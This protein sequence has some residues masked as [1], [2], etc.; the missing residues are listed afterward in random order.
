MKHPLHS[1]CPYFAMFPGDFAET[2][3]LSYTRMGDTVLDPFSGRGTTI[4]E[5]LLHGRTAIG[6]DINPVA[7]CIAGAKAD[8]PNLAEV[9]QRIEALEAGANV[10]TVGAHPNDFFR[11]CFHTTTFS[12]VSYLREALDWTGCRIDRFIAAMTLGALHGESHRSEMYLSNR[13]PRT[14]STK[15]DYSIRWWEKNGYIAPERDAFAILRKLA[16][17][18]LVKGLPTL[19]GRVV[20]ADARRCA[21]HFPEYAGSVSL[22]L[23][24][25]PYVDTTD[26]AEDQWLRL[27]FL[28]GEARPLARLHRDD[29]HRRTDEYWQFLT[30]AWAGCRDLLGSEAA[31]VVRIGGTRLSKQELF[32]GLL[33]TLEAG[34]GGLHVRPLHSGETSSIRR[35]QTN[36]FRPGT[37]PERA[38]HDF[39]FSVASADARRAA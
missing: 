37:S 7:A 18:R 20:L 11:H 12:H 5:G 1:I 27:W 28:G 21:E 35:R 3:I 2:Q 26:Y 10:A 33:R 9:L 34:L 4:L 16:V 31:V 22:L 6:V 17:F 14:I 24:S 39:A 23:T 15:P 36:S 19:K 32:E 38:E 29:R 25:P 13:M 30:E 8:V